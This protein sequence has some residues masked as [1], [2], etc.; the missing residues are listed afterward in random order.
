VARLFM[1]LRKAAEATYR[2]QQGSLLVAQ[3]GIIG[4]HLVDRL[5]A[6][7]PEIIALEISDVKHQ[8]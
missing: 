8:E 3:H 1:V 4:L 6:D 7:R 2:R 5:S